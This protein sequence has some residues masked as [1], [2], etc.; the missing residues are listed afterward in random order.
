[1]TVVRA[2]KSEFPGLTIEAHDRIAGEFLPL[3]YQH[4]TENA[5]DELWGFEY[6]WDPYTDLLSGKALSLYEYNLAYDIPLYL[7]INSAHDS[8][9]MLAFWW[10]ASCCRHLGIGGLDETDAAMAAARGGDAHLPAAA[11]LVRPRPVRRSRPADAPPR[12]RRRRWRRADGV[13]PGGSRGAPFGQ[14]GPVG[15]RARGGTCR[16]L[17]PPIAIGSQRVSRQ[18]ALVLDL[19]IAPLSPVVVEIGIGNG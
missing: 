14:C 13:Q 12:P 17:T 1:M 15:A 10:Y 3:Y 11:S 18:A 4:G 5:H 2:I 19:E 9:T 6:M 16:C 7:H 8:P